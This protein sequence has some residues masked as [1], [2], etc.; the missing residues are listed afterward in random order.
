MARRIDLLGALLIVS[1]VIVPFLNFEEVRGLFSNSIG[2]QSTSL[3]PIYIKTWKDFVYLFIF[4]LGVAQF[5]KKKVTYIRLPVFYYCCCVSFFASLFLTFFFTGVIAVFL[6]IRWF[7]PVLLFPVFFQLFTYHH[8][9]LIKNTVV[10]V[11]CLGFF[12]QCLQ[13]FD[14][15]SYFGLYVNGYSARNPGFYFMPSSMASF[16]MLVF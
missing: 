12:V 8:Q 14:G 7:F 6:G 5:V 16:T 13:F 15:I 1:I 11:F 9:I 2:S 3:T 4:I 10:S